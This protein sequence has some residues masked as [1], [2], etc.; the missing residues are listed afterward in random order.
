[1]TCSA[2]GAERALFSDGKLTLSP[3]VGG[4]LGD[5]VGIAALKD[6]MA[7]ADGI[8]VRFGAPDRLY[9]GMTPEI[10]ALA[11]RARLADLDASP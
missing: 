5:L 1:M 8:Y 6:L 10:E 9:G 7:E 4:F 2:A 3:E 11:D